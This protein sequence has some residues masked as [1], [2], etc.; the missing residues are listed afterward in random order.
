MES[1]GASVVGKE[2]H[3][4]AGALRT[5]TT[6]TVLL[7]SGTRF[8]A[9][10]LTQRQLHWA[11]LKEDTGIGQDDGKERELQINLFSH[12]MSYQHNIFQGSV[13]WVTFQ[14][15]HTPASPPPPHHF[16]ESQLRGHLWN[17]STLTMI[18]SFELS[19]LPLLWPHVNMCPHAHSLRSTKKQ[20]QREI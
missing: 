12:R 4:V 19:L 8:P 5:T 15:A 20:S 6:L 17:V 9:R 2:S 1:S 13:A 7:E 10:C 18:S 3:W 16:G 11:E 14:S